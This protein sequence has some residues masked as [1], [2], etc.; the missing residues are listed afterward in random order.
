MWKTKAFLILF[1]YLLCQVSVFAQLQNFEIKKKEVSNPQLDSLWKC[2]C[3]INIELA[4]QNYTQNVQSNKTLDEYIKEDSINFF[5]KAFKGKTKEE[6]IEESLEDI[7]RFKGNIEYLVALRKVKKGTFPMPKYNS[8]AAKA[9]YERMHSYE[10]DKLK[11]SIEDILDDSIN[12]KKT[13]KV[14]MDKLKEKPNKDWV[15][16][17]DT[18]QLGGNNPILYPGEYVTNTSTYST[19]FGDMY[20]GLLMDHNGTFYHAK[21]GTSILSM[22]VSK[23]DFWFRRLNGGTKI[24]IP[25][26]QK[27]KNLV[28][29][30]YVSLAPFTEADLIIAREMKNGSE[31]INQYA[32]VSDDLIFNLPG[33]NF[34]DVRGSLD[35]VKP[36]ASLLSDSTLYEV[37]K[38]LMT[39]WR[40]FKEEGSIN[41]K[42]EQISRFI[43]KED[44]EQIKKLE[45]DFPQIESEHKKAVDKG[46]MDWMSN[47]L[48]SYAEAY[49]ALMGVNP[50]IGISVK[51][52][53]N[54]AVLSEIPNGA[55]TYYKIKHIF[56][57]S[58]YEIIVDNKG[59]I[60]AYNLVTY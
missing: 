60:T 13:F 24:I 30:E 40:F 2:Y 58:I 55:S 52:L 31:C 25:N 46:F 21:K 59:I 50:Q 28:T 4:K 57:K 29:D 32:K 20:Y 7:K 26:Y 35:K 36:N 17:F 44:Y 9:K 1:I 14:E 16:I 54:Y 11:R 47:S 42:V 41:E 19:Y 37:A 48:K 43:T 53:K 8:S 38:D 34:I 56:N 27:I 23:Y 51:E 3:L 12:M 33:Y 15:Y 10:E 18:L 39:E 22:P 45:K 49:K 5:K 6:Y